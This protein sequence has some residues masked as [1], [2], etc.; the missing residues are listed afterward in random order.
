[1]AA[2]RA[3]VTASEQIHQR[4]L[5]I[6]VAQ[7]QLRGSS[8]MILFGFGCRFR[9]QSAFDSYSVACEAFS[10]HSRNQ[11]PLPF[12]IASSSSSCSAIELL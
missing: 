12:S 1:M 4:Q 3:C 8:I 9:F 7:F 6:S 10:E 5:P 11:L 2:S